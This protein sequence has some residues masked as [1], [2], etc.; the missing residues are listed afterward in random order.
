VKKHLII[1]AKRPF[2]HYAKTRLG[3]EIGYEQAA[4]VYARLLYTLLIDIAR[5]PLVCQ[6]LE[7]SVA[8][9]ADAAYFEAAFPE[10]VVR[11]QVTGD[12]GTRMEASFTHAF[13]AGA[14]S[15]V[16]AGSDVSGLTAAVVKQAF[17]ALETPAVAGTLPGVI[18]PAMDGGYYLIGMRAPGARLFEGIAWSTSAV[19][20]QTEALAGLHRV[21]L[22]QLPPLADVDVGADYAAWREGLRAGSPDLEVTGALGVR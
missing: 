7:L 12:L 20:A 14:E 19:L 8:S 1:Y 2:G 16:L 22:R 3:A 21:T 9:Q 4:G 15:V 10:F 18:G 6:G 17:A 13:E 11:T 5:A